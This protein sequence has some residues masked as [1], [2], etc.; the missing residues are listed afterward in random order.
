MPKRRVTVRSASGLHARPAATFT[1]AAAD[2]GLRPTI[3]KDGG[4][5]VDAS[6]ILSVMGL[7]V[8]QGDEVVLEADGVDADRVLDQLVDL[9]SQDLDA[10][11]TG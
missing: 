4:S 11:P 2:C 1:R 3:A 9:L 7:G 6:S 8:R 10:A 5:P